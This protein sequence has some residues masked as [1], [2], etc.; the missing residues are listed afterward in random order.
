MKRLLWFII[1][2]F[3]ISLLL[4][5]FT[6][7]GCSRGPNEEELQVLEETKAAAAA[8]QQKAADCEAEKASL[9]GQLAELKQKNEYL[10]NEKP[11]VEK[12]LAE[13]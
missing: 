13:M 9:E 6:F 5:S 11:T 1:A 3:L 12:R 2:L 8:G 4:V 10:K 7:I